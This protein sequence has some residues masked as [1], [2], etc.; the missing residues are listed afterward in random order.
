MTNHNFFKLCIKSNLI[1]DRIY[2]FVSLVNIAQIV[3]CLRNKCINV[4]RSI[5]IQV[6]TCTTV[7]CLYKLINEM[8]FFHSSILLNHNIN[9]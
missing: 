7:Q 5:V 8:Y 9:L 6:S 2:I 4:V 3:K 1:N